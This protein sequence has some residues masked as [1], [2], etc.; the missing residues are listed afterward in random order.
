MKRFF[1]FCLYSR[2]RVE[3][4]EDVK[5]LK[6][7][8]FVSTLGYDSI[9]WNNGSRWS[10]SNIFIFINK[11]FDLWCTMASGAI[12]TRPTN[13]CLAN[14][15]CVSNKKI[16][17][18]NEYRNRATSK[19]P[20]CVRMENKFSYLLLCSFRFSFLVLSFS[21][22]FINYKFLLF[23]THQKSETYFDS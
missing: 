14:N 6:K 19:K 11:T 8:Y 4:G 18:M 15:K 12:S 10:L 22:S 3:N 9:T 17:I 21:L 2:W 5:A 7:L 23:S 16:K 1:F 13:K 20:N